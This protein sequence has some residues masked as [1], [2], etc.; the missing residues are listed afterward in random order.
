MR[1]KHCARWH[2][3]GPIQIRRPPRQQT[4]RKGTQPATERAF[5]RAS[6]LARFAMLSLRDKD[7][8]QAL[9]PFEKGNNHG[10]KS[11]LF[12]A[13]LKRAIAQDDG[14]RVRKAAETL[15]DLAADGERWAVEM[16]ADRLDGKADQTINVVRDPGNMSLAELAAEV[17]SLRGGDTAQAEGA[18]GAGP[19][20]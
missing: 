20:H 2:K 11:R 15:L 7:L 6:D 16:L 19:V 12:D 13:A 4:K 1:A 5:L 3:A 14:K 8:P 9:M 10:A 17:A 18:N